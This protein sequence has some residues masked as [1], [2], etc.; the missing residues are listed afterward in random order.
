MGYV[1]S[2]VTALVAV[3]MVSLVAGDVQTDLTNAKALWM[4]YEFTASSNTNSDDTSLS[5]G[6]T[7]SR[8]CFCWPMEIMGPN[9]VW[10]A[11]DANILQVQTQFGEPIVDEDIINT[12]LTID[13]LFDKTQTAINNNAASIEVTYDTTYG[14]PTS[15]T[16]D[17][18]E[19]IADEEY[20]LTIDNFAP[21]SLWMNDFES[22]V[23]IWDEFIKTGT[24]ST[25]TSTRNLMMRRKLLHEPGVSSYTYTYE[26]MRFCLEEYLG[27]FIVEVDVS[28][29]GNGNIIE[30][31]TK[32]T[33]TFNNEVD[34]STNTKWNV[35]T[36]ADLHAIIHEAFESNPTPA[37]EVNVVYDD[38][39]GYPTSISIDYVEMMADEEFYANIKDVKF[40]M[41]S[42]TE[43]NNEEEEQ[44]EE[45]VNPPPPVVT[46]TENSDTCSD[47]IKLIFQNPS[48]ASDLMYDVPPIEI[49]SQYTTT[50]TFRVVQGW[51]TSSDTET[52]TVE[53]I[54]VECEDSIKNG[55]VECLGVNN[56]A[57]EEQ[58]TSQVFTAECYH[59]VPIA[60]VTLY[61][62]DRTF[63]DALLG[64][65]IDDIVQVPKCCEPTPST[66][67]IGSTIQY[68]FE[69]WCVTQCD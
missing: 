36:I 60:I 26:R 9:K 66:D 57:F 11:N 37:H 31:V 50:V 42:T 20:M 40:E 39:H 68:V 61:V 4:S 27:P 28:D 59:Q 44:E 5:Y 18:D 19:M 46:N 43:H 3:M 17:Y 15:I 10:V 25:S 21:Y 6:F 35:P 45:V 24:T 30:S 49:I 29:D 12:I 65:P 55:Q 47:D 62:S 53:S 58:V 63:E 1:T 22:N 8:S 67:S 64:T 2:V 32:V 13:E 69:L 23:D 38:E 56:V 33:N 51:K 34:D 7:Y 14:Y 48:G 41:S 52:S 54:Y 16:I